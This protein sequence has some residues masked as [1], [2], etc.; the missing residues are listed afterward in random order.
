MPGAERLSLRTGV[1][2]RGDPDALPVVLHHSKEDAR[3]RGRRLDPP[4]V[5]TPYGAWHW[6][7]GK[8]RS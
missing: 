7:G 5:K 1:I 8:P 6:R 2:V 4:A 3:R